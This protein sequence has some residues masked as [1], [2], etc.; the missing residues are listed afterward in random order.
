MTLVNFKNFHLIWSNQNKIIFHISFN[1]KDIAY[2]KNSIK[3]TKQKK[4]KLN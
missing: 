4:Q 1:D 2:L 3:K